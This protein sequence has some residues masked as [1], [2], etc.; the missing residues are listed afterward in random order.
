MSLGSKI[1]VA[2]A[3]QHISSLLLNPVMLY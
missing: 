1:F 3:F 2:I